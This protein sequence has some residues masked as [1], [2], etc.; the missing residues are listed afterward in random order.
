MKSNILNIVGA[1]ALTVL[2]A[3]SAG[4][5][6][7]EPVY[8]EVPGAAFPTTVT[9]YE[10]NPG[11]EL[12]KVTVTVMRSQDSGEQTLEL[13]SFTESDVFTVPES[14]TFEAGSLAASFDVL[15]A[16]V[17][18]PGQVQKLEIVLP[19]Y[20]ATTQAEAD[21]FGLEIAQLPDTANYSL[22]VPNSRRKFTLNVSVALL[23]EDL[24]WVLYTD[25]YMT[26]FY[27]V[28]NLTYYVPIQKAV[29]YERYRLVNPYGEVY[30]YNDPG[31]WDPKKT[32]YLTLIADNPQRVWIPT[33]ETQYTNWD[34]GN[35][36]FG[37]MADYYMQKGNSAD[38]VAN[39][40]FFGTYEDGHFTFPAKALC[41]TSVNYY[42]EGKMYYGNNNGLF[43]VDMTSLVT[44]DPYAE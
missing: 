8:P 41:C 17:T 31:D 7:D 21:K 33:F 40:G 38:A 44:E 34:I 32:S 11:D 27:S 9:T 18:E 2:S 29:G 6:W 15:V 23:W 24:G 42:A 25:D 1:A 13:K 35:F 22:L 39:A 36:M 26:T 20:V 43:D 10:L 16:P 4:Q 19:D 30:P 5:Y 28:Q 14:V 12:D 3:C 37:S